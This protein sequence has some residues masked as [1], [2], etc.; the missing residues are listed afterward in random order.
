MREKLQENE[1]ED[2]STIVVSSSDSSPESSS[3]NTI[4]TSGKMVAVMAEEDASSM[5]VDFDNVES[6]RLVSEV[7]SSGAPEQ[8]VVRKRGRPKSLKNKTSSMNLPKAKKGK[9]KE[10]LGIRENEK[11]LKLTMTI[12]IKDSKITESPTRAFADLEEGILD[13][14]LPTD[15][16]ED[17]SEMETDEKLLNSQPKAL[18]GFRIPKKQRVSTDEGDAVKKE[19]GN[20]PLKVK[21]FKSYVHLKKRKILFENASY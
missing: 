10:K 6:T 7:V 1:N 8:P 4:V 14:G 20:Q 16:D 17:T 13:D 15:K 9:R 12:N 18:V 11:P 3:R 2:P 21:F 19:N 5:D